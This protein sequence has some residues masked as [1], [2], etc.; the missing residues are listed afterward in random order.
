MAPNEAAVESFRRERMLGLVALGNDFGRLRL[1]GDGAGDRLFRGLIVEVVDLLVVFG[2]P[3]DEDADADEEIIGFFDRDDAFGDAVGNRLGDRMLRRAE[4]LDRLLGALDRDLV[5]QDRVG[6]GEQVRRD[7]REK[8]GEAVLIVDERIRE[9]AFRGA[10]AR[11]HDQIDMRNFIAVADERFADAE[12][13][14]LGHDH[15]PPVGKLKHTAE[16]IGRLE[17]ILVVSA[18]RVSRDLDGPVG[19]IAADRSAR[20]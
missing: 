8:R 6:L 7:D 3:M 15:L 10:A 16:N 13:R 4:H 2:F 1:A 14:Y 9:S 17:P 11:T 12:F 18:H 5:E 20:A 19:Q